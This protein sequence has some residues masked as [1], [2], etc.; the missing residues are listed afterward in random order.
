MQ[1]HYHRLGEKLYDGAETSS[2]AIGIDLLGGELE[3]LLTDATRSSSVAVVVSLS[4]ERPLSLGS[5][6]G[7]H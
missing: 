3:W 1:S 2:E 6:E 5:D 4:L 7:R